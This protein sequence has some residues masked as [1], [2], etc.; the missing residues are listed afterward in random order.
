MASTTLDDI[1][2]IIKKTGQN[3]LFKVEFR[4]NEND[5][6]V[7]DI[8]SESTSMP[9]QIAW[10]RTNSSIGQEFIEYVAATSVWV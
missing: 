6:I 2:H 7:M 8:S 10:P 3:P 4:I 1:R 9:R 5:D